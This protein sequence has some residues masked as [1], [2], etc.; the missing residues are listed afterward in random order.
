MPFYSFN[1]ASELCGE[2]FSLFLRVNHYG[3]LKGEGFRAILCSICGR[4]GA[5]RA[6]PKGELPVMKRTGGTWP[7]ES[8]PELRGKHY[9]DEY[10]RKSMEK[11][12]DRYAG[13]GTAIIPTDRDAQLKPGVKSDMVKRAKDPQKIPT[14]GD[15]KPKTNADKIASLLRTNGAMRAGQV[16][17]RTKI[18]INS[19]R[20][21]MQVD[22]RIARVSRGVYAFAQ[23]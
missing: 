8:P 14:S 23:S 19:V 2:Q 5:V 18:P 4:H 22:E 13:E 15:R 17:E 12:L 7:K 1:C 11:A 10:E 6:F 21:V 16:A 9:A 20:K 3:L